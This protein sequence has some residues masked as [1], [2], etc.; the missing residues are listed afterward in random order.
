[1]ALIPKVVE[2]SR[3]TETG[4]VYVL[5]DFYP[6][7]IAKRNGVNRV[8]REEFLMQLPRQRPIHGD[9]GTVIGWQDV[10]VLAEMRKNIQRF[11]AVHDAKGTTGDLRGRAR[12]RDLG[13]ADGVLAILRDNVDTTG[14]LAA[15][16]DEEL[17]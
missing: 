12:Q 1:M 16:S 2:V 6:S 5:I 11:I 3:D 13:D 7:L 14:M 9:D 15:L 8:I 4:M 10:D 17:P